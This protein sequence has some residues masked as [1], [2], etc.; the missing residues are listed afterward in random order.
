[1][2]VY[3][4]FSYVELDDSNNRENS[5]SALIALVRISYMKFDFLHPETIVACFPS[6]SEE[7]NLFLME[8]VR[9]AH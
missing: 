5:G 1:M 2:L 9:T 4:L 7:S 8:T 6:D 3:S